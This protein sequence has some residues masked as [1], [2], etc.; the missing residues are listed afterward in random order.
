MQIVRNP[1]VNRSMIRSPDAF[2]G[3]RTEV[4]RLATRIASDTLQSVSIIGERRSGK[5][6]LLSYISHPD[7]IADYLDEPERTLF[8][9]LDFQEERRPTIDK[10]IAAV[11]RHVENKLDGQYLPPTHTDYEGMQQLMSDLDA[12]GYR[13]VLLLDEFDRVTRNSTFDAPFYAFLRALAGH[14][15]IAYITSSGRDL[16]TLCHTDEIAGSAF[17]NIFSTLHVGSLQ[18]REAME[19]ICQPSSDTPYPLEPHAELILELGGLFPFFLQIACSTVFELLAEEGECNR[20][21]VLQRFDEEAHPHFQYY[22]EQM[23]PIERKLC[24]DMACQRSIN[25]QREDYQALLRR[26]IALEGGKLFSTAFAGFLRTAYARENG[27]APIEVQ[28]ERLR[29]LEDELNAARQMQKSLLP[30]ENPKIPGLDLVGR[31]QSATDVGG[32]FYTYFWLDPAC[33]RLAIVAVDVMGHGMQAAV[34]AMRFSETLRYEARGRTRATD[35]LEGLN[36]SI[37]ETLTDGSFVA[38]CIGIIDTR[39]LTCEI[40]VAAHHPPLYYSRQQNRVIELDMGGLPL[41]IK[42][43]TSYESK[44]L[45]L[46]KG[47]GLIF[48]SDGLIEAHD[49]RQ[50]EYGEERL[51]ELVLACMHQKL[52]APECLQQV[53]WDVGRFCASTG[54][55]DDMTAVVALI[56]ESKPTAQRLSYLQ[57]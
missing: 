37:C 45:D 15:N 52:D 11:F 1:Y 14:H 48:F 25:E 21:R 42:P 54:Q 34:T 57:D 29:S 56:P 9:F 51:S 7:I 5:S 23:D 27:E 32:D 50:Q 20:Q 18:K 35:I 10:F 22:W 43:E 26:G 53:F 19:L 33:T 36:R 17:F 2:Y 16:Q 55:N 40:S 30:E 3:R 47:D 49:D 44:K 31:C 4:M 41:G 8:V 12:L 39:Q 46:A 13:L 24:Y 28:A 6:S 38:C